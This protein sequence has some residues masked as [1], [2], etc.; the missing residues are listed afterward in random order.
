M[1]A[2]GCSCGAAAGETDED[3]FCLR[4]GLRMRK[5][6]EFDH[7]EQVVSAAF[8]AVTDRGLKHD[9]NEDRFAVAEIAGVQAMVVCDGVS[10]TSQSEIASA[11]VAQGALDSLTRALEADPKLDPQAALRQAI[12]D[13]ADRLIAQSEHTDKQNPPSTTVVAALV[14]GGEAIIGWMGDSRAYWIDD[15]GAKALTHDH[16]WMNRA[17]GEEGMSAE[18]AAKAPQAHAITRWIGADSTERADPSIVRHTV[19]TPG[20]LLLCTDGLWNYAATDDVLMK[21][22][23]DAAAS[24]PDAVDLARALV[25]FANDHGGQDNITVAVL[26]FT[27]SG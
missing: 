8:A 22:V 12:A 19:T 20:M 13:G 24:G 3:G 9:R 14:L 18:Q 4:C 16:S 15:S 25:K 7:V 6:L 23:Q 27:E 21:V 10:S 11:A 5:A 1:A 17:I 26:R 2:G